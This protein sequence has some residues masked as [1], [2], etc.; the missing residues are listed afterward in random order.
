VEVRGVLS[1]L[2]EAARAFIADFNGDNWRADCGFP[3]GDIT[4]SSATAG[5]WLCLL[6][7]PS[8]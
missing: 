5:G 2:L 8:S 6:L 3:L 7:A 1:R 4:I